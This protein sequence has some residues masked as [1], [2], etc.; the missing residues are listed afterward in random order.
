MLQLQLPRITRRVE[1]SILHT[2]VLFSVELTEKCLPDMTK[3]THS[4]HAAPG[5]LHRIL[6]YM[7]KHG[8]AF[9]TF[10][11]LKQMFAENNDK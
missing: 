5:K 3:E 11:S 7:L 2:V 4:T 9:D 1:N 6:L 8:Y 10:I